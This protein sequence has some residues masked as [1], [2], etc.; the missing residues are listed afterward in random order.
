MSS[1]EEDLSAAEADVSS[2]DALAFLF[3]GGGSESPGRRGELDRL[4]SSQRQ[5]RREVEN[6]RTHAII[7]RGAS[8]EAAGRRRALGGWIFGGIFAC[9]GFV[10]FGTH[11]V[12]R[13][14]PGWPARSGSVELGTSRVVGKQGERGEAKLST[15]QTRLETR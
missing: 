2:T 4:R 13:V 11:L 14:V 8:R 7:K 9:L 3:L 10:A 15:R 12:L 1:T 5:S 6:L